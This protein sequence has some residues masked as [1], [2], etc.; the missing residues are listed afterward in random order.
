VYTQ[1]KTTNVA[2]NVDTTDRADL[3]L[4]FICKKFHQL[5]ACTVVPDEQWIFRVTV[6]QLQYLFIADKT[7]NQFPYLSLF[8]FTLQVAA[9]KLQRCK[10]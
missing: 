4:L 5:C 7:L 3:V 10:F 6:Q 9:Y 2:N 1:I 8:M